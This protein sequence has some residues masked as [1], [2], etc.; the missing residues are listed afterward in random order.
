M[1]EY[2]NIPLYVF[3][4]ERFNLDK[5]V[6]KNIIDLIVKIKNNDISIE[7]KLSFISV[8][9]SYLYEEDDD[10][11][12][13]YFLNN[14]YYDS[15][16]YQK[17]L[18]ISYDLD[19]FSITQ[20]LDKIIDEF[21]IYENIIKIGNVN[22]EII[23]IDKLLDIGKMLSKAGYDIYYFN[24]YLKKVKKKDYKIE[25][26]T[27]LDGKDAVNLLT[28]HKSK[29]LEYKICYFASLSK[30]FNLSDIKEDIIY[31]L[32]YKIVVP[33]FKDNKSDSI[34]KVLIKDN[35]LKEEISEKIRLFYVALTRAKEK[36]ILVMNSDVNYKE[37]DEFMSFKDML[38]YVNPKID[39]YKKEIDI[40]SLGL[41]LD[42]LKKKKF[43]NDFKIDEEKVKVME[44]SLEDTIVDSQSF[45]KKTNDVISLDTYNNMKYGNHIH[46]VFEKCDFKSGSFDEFTDFERSK[47]NNFLN[48]E[49][50]KNIMLANIYHE[51]E[52]IYEEDDITYHG[53]IDLMLEY[54]NHIDIIDYKLNDVTDSNYLKQLKGYQ[55]YI[56]KKT[57]KTVN[58][59]LYSI[60]QDK[61]VNMGGE[62]CLN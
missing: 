16:L 12:F 54:N 46:E 13:S 22:K 7:F 52:F 37:K 19:N 45:S 55:N 27:N 53:I 41:S 11:I 36:I 59:Y 18:K 35:Y 26:Q 3:K 56:E 42:Y 21:N 25:Y 31:D 58:I 50:V 57:G 29:G 51:Y 61:M 24:D 43:V 28:I 44:I 62:L 30:K 1:F 38:D 34:Y 4:D 2:F 23:E 39:K 48:Q 5:N 10:T 8:L 17:C 14:N 20:I 32:K 47:I 33:I 6:I 49:V 40:N 60:L 9:R 15:N